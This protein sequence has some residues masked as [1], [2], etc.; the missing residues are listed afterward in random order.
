MQTYTQIKDSTC[1]TPTFDER[2]FYHYCLVQQRGT[3]HLYPP[4]LS[5]S[6]LVVELMW[7][8]IPSPIFSITLATAAVSP[9]TQ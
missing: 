8:L 7:I 9:I 2:Y 3:N 4:T 1:F 5:S 6:S